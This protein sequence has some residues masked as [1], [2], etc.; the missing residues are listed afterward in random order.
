MITTHRRNLRIMWQLDL[1]TDLVIA[2]D[3]VS[4]SQTHAR[5]T[6]NMAVSKTFCKN[7]PQHKKTCLCY[8]E[9]IYTLYEPGHAKMC[10]MPY[11]NNIGADQLAHPRSLISAFVVRSF[12]SMIS[13]VSRSKISRFWLVSVAGLNVTW[14][15]TLEDTFSLGGAHIM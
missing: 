3:F 6:T 10:L 1:L 7:K 9:Q 4:S 15:Q 13:L 2:N 11:A 12:D 14:S 8:M 5:K